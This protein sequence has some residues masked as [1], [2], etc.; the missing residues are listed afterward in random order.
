MVWPFPSAFEDQFKCWNTSLVLH[1]LASGTRV[2]LSIMAGSSS[3]QRFYWSCVVPALSQRTRNKTVQ[4]PLDL[5]SA[6]C[7]RGVRCIGIFTQDRMRLVMSWARC[8]VGSTIDVQSRSISAVHEALLAHSLPQ[9]EVNYQMLLRSFTLTK[10]LYQR[11][12]TTLGDLKL[13]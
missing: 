4:V 2:A 7:C 12:S 8:L 5:G 3:A 10:C 13:S 11:Q 9:F 1:I 6:D